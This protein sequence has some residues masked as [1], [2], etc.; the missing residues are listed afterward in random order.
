[1]FPTCNTRLRGTVVT[2]SLPV[3][4]LLNT[5]MSLSLLHYAFVALIL[6]W[7]IARALLI[8][9][10]I[11]G[12]PYSFISRC[13]PWGELMDLAFFW[14]PSG[15]VFDWFSLQCL[16]HESPLVQLFFP[17]FSTTHP[18]LVL[19][20]L[21]E[22]EDIVTKRQGEIDRAD[23]MQSWFGVLGPKATIGLRTKDVHF[24]E[25][26]R[27]WNVMLSPRF[28]EDVAAQRFYEAV[29]DLSRLWEKKADVIG[30]NYAYAAQEDL[31]MAT[32]DAMWRT[33]VGSDLGLVAAKK[34]KLECTGAG[35]IRLNGVM[36]FPPADMPEF[37]DAMMTMLVCTDWVMTGVSPRFYT[38]VFR[39]TAALPRAEK[40]KDK[41]LDDCIAASKRRVRLGTE[42]PT[43]ALDEV[44]RK[45][46]RLREKRESTCAATNDIAVRDEL[47]QILITGHETTASSIAWTLKYLTDYPNTQV[48]LRS[49]LYSAFPNASPSA[50]PSAKC[51]LGT[52]LPY[53][54]A[55]IAEVLRLAAPGPI[56]FRQ[57]LVSCEIL[58]HQVPAGTPLILMTAGPS[59]D[60]PS[61]PSIPE[62][63]RSRSS[64]AAILRK[65][66]ETSS[67]CAPVPTHSPKLDV[68]CPERWLVDGKFDPHAVYM[69]P[70]SAGPR[71]CFGRKIAMLEMKLFIAVLLMRF[72]FPRLAKHLSPYG[73]T[74]GLT[75]RLKS[76][77]VNPKLYQ[78]GCPQAQP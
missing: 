28:L 37:Y 14:L 20:D 49:S 10:A 12:I 62:G 2:T 51:I 71:G 74:D 7:V 69:L 6:L 38:W 23:A 11:P 42:D 33:C 58:G 8:P 22:I 67:S 34:R 64:Q 55:V 18:T 40:S 3:L 54:D 32:L 46:L 44:H 24:R 41:L 27:L 9:K 16:K 75:R 30:G 68:F 26:R 1:M 19:A 45:D 39:H 53:L 17:P 25:Q 57:T 36:E 52:S 61:M 13:M 66:D 29:V 70:F 21:R 73:A 59:Y 77:Y 48:Q 65:S 56:S 76:C 43:C 50:L 78:H 15:E 31:R 5:V 47:M 35:K 63:V 4:Y 72:E 60:S